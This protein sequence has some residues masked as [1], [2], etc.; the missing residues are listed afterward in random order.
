MTTYALPRLRAATPSRLWWTVLAV[1]VAA[2]VALTVAVVVGS[3]LDVL[4]RR[5][6]GLDFVRRWPNVAPWVTRY[7]V[8]AQRGPS[9]A[10]AGAYLCWRAWRMRS[11]RPVVML[12]TSLLLLN[13]SVGAVKLAIGRLGPLLTSHP[14]AV[15]DGGDIFPSGHTSNAVVVFG[16]LAMVASRHRR[17]AVALAVFGATT[18]GLS[19]VFLDT[20]WVTDVV[21]GW[22]A[23]AI[24]L[25]VLPPAT[26]G[27][28]GWISSAKRSRKSRQGGE[29]DPLGADPAV[30]GDDRTDSEQHR[31]LHH[32]SGAAPHFEERAVR[33][34]PPDDADLAYDLSRPAQRRPARV[35]QRDLAPPG[36]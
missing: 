13:V 19:T 11:S 12:V 8:I 31:A 26:S 17:L 5:A 4:D 28:Q 35:R 18:V 3:P 33:T 25:V 34:P 36:R 10:V 9:A 15:F 22:L 1:L 29:S 21:G 30:W 2:Y 20:H 14:R 6:A 32:A 27:V 23:G 7:V 24:I 16:V